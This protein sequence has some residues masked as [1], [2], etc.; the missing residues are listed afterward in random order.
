MRSSCSFPWSVNGRLFVLRKAA[1][2]RITLQA[3]EEGSTLIAAFG[4]A[5]LFD[6][7]RSSSR[8]IRRWRLIFVIARHSLA[9]VARVF[10]CTFASIATRYCFILTLNGG[11]SCRIKTRLSPTASFPI[12]KSILQGLLKQLLFCRHLW[13]NR[14]V[15]LP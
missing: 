3:V 14:Y 12:S 7:S 15:I 1:A 5:G 11:V 8:P 13:Y 4:S 10:Y 9:P 2:V 6:N